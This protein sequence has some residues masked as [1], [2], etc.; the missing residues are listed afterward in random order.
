VLGA[1]EDSG[2]AWQVWVMAAQIAHALFA[3]NRPEGR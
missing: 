2:G 3:A 1:G